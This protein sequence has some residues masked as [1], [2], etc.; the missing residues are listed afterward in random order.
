MCRGVACNLFFFGGGGKTEVPERSEGA[1]PWWRSG[2]E[3][4]E[5]EDICANNHCNNVLTKNPNFFNMEIF[6][7]GH[8]P[9][10]PPSIRPWASDLLAL[11]FSGDVGE[12]AEPPLET[13]LPL[14]RGTSAHISAIYTHLLQNSGSATGFVADFVYNFSAAVSTNLFSCSASLFVTQITFL[15]LCSVCQYRLLQQRRTWHLRRD[16][17]YYRKYLRCRHVFRVRIP[18]GKLA[19]GHGKWRLHLHLKTNISCEI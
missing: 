19:V 5:A 15:F 6:G 7:G 2:G 1:E 17:D 9:L 18:G 3:D 14:G 8:V 16:K 4:P 11:A 10:V 12:G 13:P